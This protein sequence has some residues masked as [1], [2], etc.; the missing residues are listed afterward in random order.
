MSII[1]YVWNAFRYDLTNPLELTETNA[2]K[3]L[4]VL[5][6]C[7]LYLLEYLQ[8]GGKLRKIVNRDI[9]QIK[10]QKSAFSKESRTV[11]FKE[12][13]ETSMQD[14]DNKSVK[15]HADEK[16]EDASKTQIDKSQ[17]TEEDSKDAGTSK[18]PKWYDKVS[19]FDVAVHAS[20]I[21]FSI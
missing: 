17:A 12:I 21:G 15:S 1:L 16:H 3:P 20:F 9:D 7:S 6:E 11:A 4:T 19:E 10:N 18:G 8:K 13:S 5:S 2:W 14:L